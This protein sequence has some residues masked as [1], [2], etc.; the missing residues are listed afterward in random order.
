MN[1][2]EI[3][4]K[5]PNQ[6]GLTKKT[7]SL[8]SIQ[9]IVILVHFN[10]ECDEISYIIVTVSLLIHIRFISVK[11]HKLRKFLLTLYPETSVRRFFSKKIYSSRER[12]KTCHNWLG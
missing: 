9:P 4:S 12:C 8:S 2:F 11:F 6:S 3:F 7:R 1:R 5:K 10:A